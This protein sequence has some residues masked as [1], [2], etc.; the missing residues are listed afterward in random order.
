MVKVIETGSRL[1]ATGG[2]G[3]EERG[4]WFNGDRVSAGKEEKLVEMDGGDGC[5][6]V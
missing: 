6:A 4:A 1:V 5:T 3:R 2:W